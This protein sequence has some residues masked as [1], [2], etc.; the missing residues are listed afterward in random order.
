[1]SGLVGIISVVPGDFVFTRAGTSQTLPRCR[2]T[3]LTPRLL[4]QWTQPVGERISTTT[5]VVLSLP[6]LTSAFSISL[7]V[8][9]FSDWAESV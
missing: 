2:F 8:A 3:V 4:V 6:E 5:A 9:S 7:W 1:M